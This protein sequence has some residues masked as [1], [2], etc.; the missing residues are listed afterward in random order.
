MEFQL[1]NKAMQLSELIIQKAEYQSSVLALQANDSVTANS[2]P[3][4][5]LLKDN[6]LEFLRTSPMS[7]L[8][9]KLSCIIDQIKSM[10]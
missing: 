1:E 6:F 10:Q 5:I 9:R 3:I 4:L 2:Q 7:W 8:K